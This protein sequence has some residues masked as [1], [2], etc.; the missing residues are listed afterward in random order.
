MSA[1][2][3]SAPY[4]RQYIHT[5]TPTRAS[6][7]ATHLFPSFS[8]LISRLLASDKIPIINSVRGTRHNNSGPS[9]IRYR[10]TILSHFYDDF[11]AMGFLEV[12]TYPTIGHVRITI[13]YG[14]NS[15]FTSFWSNVGS[16]SPGLTPVGWLER[17]K[18][19]SSGQLFLV[20]VACRVR[21]FDIVFTLVPGQLRQRFQLLRLK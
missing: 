5:V 13:A 19:L 7:W 2:L 9:S 16:V 18:L 10:M 21:C 4:R 1:V 20:L 11:L 6:R 17:M 15:V 12:P 8:F 14:S 3:R